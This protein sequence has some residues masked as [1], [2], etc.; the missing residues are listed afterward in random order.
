MKVKME[1]EMEMEMEMNGRYQHY[2][3]NMKW[4]HSQYYIYFYRQTF[5]S[6]YLSALYPCRLARWHGVDTLLE[7]EHILPQALESA[8]LLWKQWLCLCY[9]RPAGYAL[10]WTGSQTYSLSDSPLFEEDTLPSWE[11]VLQWALELQLQNPGHHFTRWIFRSLWFWIWRIDGVHLGN[12]G[13]LILPYLCPPKLLI[14]IGRYPLILFVGEGYS[15][16]I[17]YSGQ[18]WK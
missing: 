2:I 9:M 1:M 3:K 4:K 14:L 8:I 16:P 15:L 12:G 18:R 13:I 17:S 6:P 10:S 11:A 7:Y 5:Y